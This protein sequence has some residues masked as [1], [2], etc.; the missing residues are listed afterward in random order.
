MIDLI[1]T[2]LDRAGEHATLVLVCIFLFAAIDAALGVGAIL[3]GETGI[4]LAAMALADSPLHV[5]LAVVAAATGAFLG[6]HI[7]FAV[8][9]KLG[10]RLGETRLINRLGQDRWMTARDFVARQFWVVIV[11]RLMPGIRTLVAAAAGASTIRYRRFAA[12]CAVAAVIWA[13]LWVIGGATIGPVLLQ[14]VDRYTIPSLLVAG[15]AVLAAIIVQRRR[16]RVRS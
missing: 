10:P 15:A 4:V 12:I 13:T 5:A 16:A 3:P 14:I 6:D 9:R 7:G 1:W 11:A 8:G 2:L